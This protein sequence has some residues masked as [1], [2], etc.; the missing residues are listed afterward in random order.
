METTM[1]GEIFLESLATTSGAAFPAMDQLVASGWTDALFGIH[2][3]AATRWAPV[4]LAPAVFAEHLGASAAA[5]AS[6][7]APAWPTPAAVFGQL[8][9]EDLYLAC[10]VGH[11]MPGASE[12]FVRRFLEPITSAVHAVDNDPA[13]VDEVRQALHERL[14]LASRGPPQVLK[15]GGRASLATWVGVAAQRQ[16]LGI[17]RG[18]AARQ[19]A[20]DRAS[21]EPML[22]D[23]DPELAYLKARYRDAFREALILG[24]ARLPSRQRMLLRLYNVAGLTLQRIAFLMK[25]DESTVSR[26]VQKARET[27]LEETQRELGQQ[28]GIRVADVPSIARLVTSQLDLSVTRLLSSERSHSDLKTPL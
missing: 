4:V 18:E 13:L 2:Q 8:H 20:V 19:R 16:A 10:A 28:L 23:L 11:G 12:L 6:T 15:Y 25:V 7:F 3:V 1:L 17:L 9:A 21:D 5:L 24:L 22:P 14:L 27:I 26:W